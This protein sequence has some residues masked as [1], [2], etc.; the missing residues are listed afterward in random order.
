[1]KQLEQRFGG[2]AELQTNTFAGAFAKTKNAF[3]DVLEEIGNI[4]IKSPLIIAT[5][6]FVGAQFEWA[7]NQIAKFANGKDLIQTLALAVLDFG[8]TLIT[9]VVAPLELA[10]N[11]GVVVFNGLKTV[12]QTFITGLAS[13]MGAITGVLAKLSPERFGEIDA[14]I[15]TFAQSSK[16]L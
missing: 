7:A 14:S 15:Q 10:Y 9:F 5:M 16:I 4:I 1:M 6:K 11:T 13:G 3:G 12:I 2:L 8:K